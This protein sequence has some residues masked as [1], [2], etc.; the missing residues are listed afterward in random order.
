MTFAAAYDGVRALEKDRP[1]VEQIKRSTPWHLWVI[2][3]A[4]LAWNG[5]GANDYVQTHTGNLDYFQQMSASIGTTPEVALAHFAGFPAWA[6]AFWALGVWGA[7][8]GSVLL[9]LRKSWAIHA[10]AIALVGLAGTTFYQ[11][12][13]D[14]PEWASGDFARI[15]AIVIWSTTTFLLVYAISMRRK[16]VLV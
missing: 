8:A 10:F 13:T 6:V 12:I 7:V 2:G 9:L 15:M 3:I 11:A 14:A 16:G 4:S 1:I 5:V